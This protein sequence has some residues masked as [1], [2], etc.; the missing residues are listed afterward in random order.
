MFPP[1]DVQSSEVVQEEMCLSRT[2]STLGE[3]LTPESVTTFAE[4]K[5]NGTICPS[6]MGSEKPPF[7]CGCGKCA[8][9]TFMA[10]GC[11]KPIPSAS[12]FPYL[13]P[14]G[15]T[16]EQ[17]QDLKELSVRLRIESKK[18]NTK[19]Q[20]LVSTT[21]T[22][23]QKQQVT[24]SDFLPHLMTFGTDKPVLKDSQAPPLFNQRLDDLQK[25]RDLS[26]VFMGLKDYNVL[27]QLSSYRAYH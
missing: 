18:I 20:Y 17:Q 4:I 23:L 19:F 1:A 2:G 10:I 5:S 22:S 27:F 14:S 12:S 26:E 15:F 11:P 21:L 8:F 25:S 24:V 16:P 9:F 6:S 7:G 13:D 3:E